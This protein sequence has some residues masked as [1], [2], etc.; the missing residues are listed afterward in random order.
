MGDENETGRGEGSEKETGGG[1][2][3]GGGGWGGAAMWLCD[4]PSERGGEMIAFLQAFDAASS[5]L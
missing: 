5:K 1:G 4:D 2:G 3:G